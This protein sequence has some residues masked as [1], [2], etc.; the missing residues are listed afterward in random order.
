MIWQAIDIDLKRLIPAR[1]FGLWRVFLLL[2]VVITMAG[3]VQAQQTIFNVP[4]ADITEKNSF[5]YQHQMGLRPW[6]PN[7]YWQMTNNLGYGIGKYTELDATLIGIDA[8]GGGHGWAK[9]MGLGLG[10]KT[11]VPILPRKY[12][13]EE[14]KVVFGELLPFTFQ[15]PQTLGTWSYAMVSGRLPKVG[16]RLTAG[17]DYGTRQIFGMNQFSAM[18]GYEHP[19]NSHWLLQGDWFSGKHGQG[20][21]IPGIVYIFSGGTML[22]FGYLVPNPGAQISSCFI[23]ELTAFGNPFHLHKKQKQGPP[24]LENKD[25][26]RLPQEQPQNEQKP[27]EQKQ[28]E[29]KNNTNDGGHSDASSG[30][31]N[32]PEPVDPSGKLENPSPKMQQQAS[33]REQPKQPELNEPELNKNEEKP[34]Q[35]QQPRDGNTSSVAEPGVVY[36]DLN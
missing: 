19:I 35:A 1:N 33:P 25:E 29:P 23:F 17:V 16:T 14:L 11:A 24:E 28:N 2:A 7:R 36:L 8:F 6:M 22:S 21:F 31:T 10:F 27:G 13:A 34:A 30:N 4:S 20:A 12:K 3:R 26:K 9:Q 5:F 18:L 15:N 32:Q